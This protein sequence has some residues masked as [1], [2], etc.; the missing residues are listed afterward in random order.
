MV[1]KKRLGRG[2]DA[3][4]PKGL[5]KESPEEQASTETKDTRS[6]GNLDEVPIEF[7]RAG[8]YQPRTHFAEESIEELAESIKAQGVMQPIVLRPVDS[9]RY[10]II[11]GERRW[12]AAQRAGMEKIPAVIRDVDDESALA[13][14]L[15]ENIQREDLNPL[16]EAT[17]LQRLVDDFQFTH[18]EVAEAVGKSRSAV[19]NTLRL[20]HLADPVAEMLVRGDLEMGHARALLT[21]EQDNQAEI[22]RSIVAKGLNVRQTEALVR[23][24]GKSAAKNA[25][26]RPVDSDTRRL[27]QNLGQQ[28]GQP[29]QIKHS[30]KGKGKLI[31]SYSSLDELDGILGRMG[32]QE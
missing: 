16:E 5:P 9:G 21:L 30:R 27:E 23:N 15:I 26:T 6:R 14:S 8:K 32:Y 22:A 12:R 24:L 10:E 18:Q 25:G 3:L 2:L 29:V 7:I 4:L 28:I 17:A 20:T 1:A 31:I 13:M 19:T 11:A